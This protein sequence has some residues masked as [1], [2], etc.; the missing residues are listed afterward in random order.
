MRIFKKVT[1]KAVAE[2]LK[3]EETMDI[4]TKKKLVSSIE[5]FLEGKVM[6]R[7]N[8]VRLIRSVFDLLD[9]NVRSPNIPG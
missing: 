8:P 7:A 4:N 9:E 3:Q 1:K 2:F 5:I 6:I